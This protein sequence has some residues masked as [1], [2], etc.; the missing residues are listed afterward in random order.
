MA[1]LHF[2]AQLVPLLH[3]PCSGL[4]KP[5]LSLT[6]GKNSPVTRLNF[7]FKNEY[8]LQVK[9]RLHTVFASNTNASEGSNETKRAD[10]A[11][12]PPFLTIVAGFLVFAF[13]CWIIGSIMMWIVGLIVHP[14]PLK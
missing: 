7:R 11:Q 5:P 12:G 4:H 2:S 10:A 6:F 3:R 1:S 13:I 14:P 8:R 9:P